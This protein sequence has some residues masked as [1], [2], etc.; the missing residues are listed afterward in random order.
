MPLHSKS[1]A[2]KEYKDIWM[3]ITKSWIVPV[4]L[5]RE[6]Y[7]EKI[8]IYFA[9]MQFYL[10]WLIVPSIA[11]IIFTIISWWNDTP[12]DENKSYSFYSFGMA[13]WSTLFVVYW[14]RK[15]WH[16]KIKWGN[17][18]TET[19]EENQRKEFYGERKKDPVNGMEVLQFSTTTRLFLY[20]QSFL[21]TIPMLLL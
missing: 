6:Y 13:I 14:K 16:Y 19:F 2:K 18:T 12:I 7:G 21:L 10:I 15:T 4:E 1:R 11:S 9:W 5:I 3:E 8:A 17:Y 20:F